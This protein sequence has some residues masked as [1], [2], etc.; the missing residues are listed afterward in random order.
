MVEKVNGN[1]ASKVSS[2]FSSI[3]KRE[4]KEVSI[5]CHDSPDPDAIA[6][7]LAVRE[8]S[9]KFKLKSSIYYGGEITHSQNKA[10]INVLDIPI[11]KIGDLEESQIEKIKEKIKNSAIVVVDTSDF[12]SGNCIGP[13]ILV[14]NRKFP[15][16]IIDHHE[17]EEHEKAIYINKTVGACSSILLNI[18][19]ALKI[20]I[21]KRIATALYIGLMKDTDHLNQKEI[22]TDDD[23]N[24][25]I[26]LKDRIDFDDYLRILNCPKPSI[27][28]ELK[29]LAF[30]KY[31]IRKGNCIV[32][33]VGFIKS[34]HR[35]LIAEIAD[36]FMC[37]DQVEKCIV[38]GI[39]DDG[40]GSDK[41]LVSSLRHTGDILDAS[42]FTRK[43][44]GKNGSGGRKGSG[45]SRIKTG[46]ILSTTIDE[47]AGNDDKLDSL[48][49][50]VFTAY[51]KKIFYEVQIQS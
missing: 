24:A 25:H 3:S 23:K 36:D 13:G 43:I 30:N 28:M 19:R 11:F 37:Y 16:L 15:D 41:Y 39:I 42:E 46:P 29:G 4:K 35:S 49:D 17:S 27:L 34:P 22:L 31:N 33:G 9:K 18:L 1:E 12:C 21:D 47:L 50:T 14:D 38:I 44:F 5:F 26:Y 48:F 45:G 8:I 20:R 7:A 40:V 10:M 2:F 51:S 6:S 32:A